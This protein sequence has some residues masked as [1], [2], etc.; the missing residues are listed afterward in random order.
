MDDVFTA[1]NQL[2]D[3]SLFYMSIEKNFEKKL[4]IYEKKIRVLQIFVLGTVGS[5]RKAIYQGW[6]SSLVSE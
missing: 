4:E 6:C 1:R 3:W 5:S 2:T